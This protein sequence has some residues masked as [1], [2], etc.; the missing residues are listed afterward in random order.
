LTQLR[1]IRRFA[2]TLVAVAGAT[3]PISAQT[4]T[5]IN[6]VPYTINSSGSYC[7]NADITTSVSSGAAIEVAASNVTL[8][9]K[10]KTLDGTGAGVGTR[11]DGIHSLDRRGITVRNG[12]IVG[13]YVGVHLDFS[14]DSGDHVVEGIRF[15][16]SRW[17]AIKL[18]GANNI[19]RNNL[20]L[21]TGGGGNHVDGVSACENWFGGS[22]QALNNTIINVGVGEPDSSPDGM[23]L[24][25]NTAVAIGNRVRNVGDSG[26][27]LGG[28]YCKDNVLQYVDGRP[29]DPGLGNGCTLIGSTN[30][31]Y[32]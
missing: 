2:F 17:K 13:F 27:S 28:G 8:D 21:D 23:M 6:S 7:L 16:H 30:F 4:C 18:E 32:P 25:C 31:N 3:R 20:I 5:S 19:M 9:L 11:A 15:E 26:I 12:R 22:V 10:G 1:F 14:S 29:Y 24:Y